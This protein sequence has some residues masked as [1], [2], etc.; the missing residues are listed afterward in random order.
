MVVDDPAIVRQVRL[1][2][3]TLLADAPAVLVVM[4]DLRL[5]VDR[6]GPVGVVSS[7]IDSGAAGENIWLAAT[8]LGLG[9]QFTMISAMTGI[10]V[11]LGLPDHFR[12]DL[13]MPFGYRREAP[14]RRAPTRIR[15]TVHWNTFGRALRPN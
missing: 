10:R 8:A 9:S 15:P 14:S 12:V 11:I 2:S 3:A 1:I 6:V 5:S 13:I 7:A 4:T